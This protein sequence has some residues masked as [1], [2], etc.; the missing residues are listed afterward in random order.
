MR[1]LDGIVGGVS[2]MAHLAMLQISNDYGDDTELWSL[3][4]Q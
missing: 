4:V 2:L 1:F 3:R